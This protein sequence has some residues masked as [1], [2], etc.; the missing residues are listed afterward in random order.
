LAVVAGAG[1]AVALV[2]AYRRQRELEESG[3]RDRTRLLT[4]RL[5]AAAVQLGGEQT[6]VRLA[7]VYAIAALADEWEEQR[8]QCISVLCGYLRLPYAGDPAPGHPVSVS[9]ERLTEYASHQQ[10]RTETTLYRPGEGHVRTA[11]I[12]TIVSHLQ[13]D[14][15]IS[16]SNLDYDFRDAHMIN[17]SFV[18]AHFAGNVTLFEGATFAGEY[19]SF[20][21]VTFAGEFGSFRGATFASEYTSFDGATFSSWNTFF[22]DASFSGRYTS[23]H[24]AEFSGGSA[25]LVNATFAGEY[26]S[27]VDAT[28]SVD[29][30][31]FDRATFAGEE[32][33]F[34]GATF[35]GGTISFSRATFCG[36]TTTFRRANFPGRYTSFDGATLAAANVSFDG[37]K[38]DQAVEAMALAR[39][40]SWETV[41][42]G[43][44]PPRCAW[45]APAATAT[46]PP[47]D[48]IGE[49]G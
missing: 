22:N 30:V 49:E 1:A 37:A 28:F 24:R 2:V 46:N 38:V 35:S 39:L 4:E 16:W 47:R 33:W 44:I 27:F 20:N 17:A 42:W 23:F 14:A 25:L 12:D 41:N 6:A 48:Q 34:D 8:Q 45:P 15:P 5:A 19:T 32:T 40:A 29:N 9:E 18:S 3:R 10:R 7:G 13:A 31:Q 43:P 36:T 21:D 26:T 11:I